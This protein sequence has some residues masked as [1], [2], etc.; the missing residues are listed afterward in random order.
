MIGREIRDDLAAFRHHNF[1]FDMCG[2]GSIFGA[3]P[4]FDREQHA[5]LE[6]SILAAK[7]PREDGAP[8]RTAPRQFVYETN[9]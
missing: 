4:A 7:S 1:F 6:H 5:F 2:P 8:S 9:L 3:F